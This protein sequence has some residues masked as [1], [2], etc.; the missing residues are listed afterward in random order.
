MSAALRIINNKRKPARL[1]KS[2]ESADQ[3]SRTSS[4]KSVAKKPRTRLRSPSPTMESQPGPISTSAPSILDVATSVANP[5]PVI[6]LE[7][8]PQAAGAT[9]DSQLADSSVKHAPVLHATSSA[10][11]TTTVAS[12][13][14]LVA[15]VVNNNPLTITPS[16]GRYLLLTETYCSINNVSK[17]S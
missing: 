8:I 4:P 10:I 15:P 5:D 1:S 17:E 9:L 13:N 14:L 6:S 16:H 2:S 11:D 3:D 7:S 12:E